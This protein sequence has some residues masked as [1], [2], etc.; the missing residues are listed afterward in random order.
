MGFSIPLAAWLRGPL[1]DS[2]KKAVF[3]PLL[4]DT[5]IFNEQYLK[6]MVDEHLARLKDHSTA[7]WQVLMFEAFLRKN[8]A[9]AILV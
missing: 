6:R 7:L 4:R 2:M 5:G 8:G 9:D 1:A 3:S